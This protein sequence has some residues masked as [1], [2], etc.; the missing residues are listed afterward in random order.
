MTK[1]PTMADDAESNLASLCDRLNTWAR[2]LGVEETNRYLDLAEM[3]NLLDRVVFAAK[4]T[5]PQ[6]W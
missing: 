1:L 3:Q 4:A 2:E 6:R 5:R